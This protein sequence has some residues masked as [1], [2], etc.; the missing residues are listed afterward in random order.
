[1]RGTSEKREKH[2]HVLHEIND[3]PYL[4]L[5]SLLEVYHADGNIN[6]LAEWK[7]TMFQ[8]IIDF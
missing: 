7:D 3:I 8:E 5:A 4:R 6:N 1:M 2:R